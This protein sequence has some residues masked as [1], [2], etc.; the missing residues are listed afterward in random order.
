M[1]KGSHK[2][3]MKVKCRG[4]MEVIGEI[5]V[6]NSMSFGGVKIPSTPDDYVPSEI[7][8]IK[9]ETDFKSMKNTVQW[10]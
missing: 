10:Y 9:G 3:F 7:N 6:E 4:S 5:F 2:K 8:T 1:E